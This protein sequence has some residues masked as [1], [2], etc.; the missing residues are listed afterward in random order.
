MTLV[1]RAIDQ[2]RTD[3]RNARRGRGRAHDQIWCVFDQDEHPQVPEALVLARDHGVRV[4]FSNPCIEL[5][6]A[7]HFQDQTAYLTRGAAQALAKSFL[8]CDKNL[9]AEAKERLLNN[10]DSARARAIALDEKHESDGSPMG[11]NPSSGLWRLI[12]E[13]KNAPSPESG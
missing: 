7:L 12:D 5:W 13:V 8:S 6:F 9:S 10:Y 1:R 11:S 2:H 4:A 3:T